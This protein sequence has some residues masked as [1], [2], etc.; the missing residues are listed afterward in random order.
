M[1]RT[2]SRRLLNAAGLL[3]AVLVFNFALIHMAPGDPVEVLAG[4]MGG[5]TPELLAE[6]RA[7]YGLDR[8]FHVQ[9]L[10]YLGRVAQGDLGHSFYYDQ[11][12]T[13]L[14]LDRIGATLLLVCAALTLALLLGCF[15]G[16][17]SA[18]NRNGWLS[19]LVT[20]LSLAGFSAPVFW[21][22]ILLILT[23]SVALPVLPISGMSSVDAGR[24]GPWGRAA[25]VAAHMVLPV[26][27]LASIY[28][29]FYSRLARASMLD[30]LGSDYVRT[31][32]AKGL[33]RFL[34]VYKH[35]LRNALLPV[36]TFAGLQFAQVVSGA[37]LVE[38]VFAWPGLGT[39][40]YESLLRRDSPTLLGIL[41]FSALMVVAV[42]IAV[43]L[44]YRLID[45]R[46]GAR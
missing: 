41:F 27:T 8:P 28:L 31:A 15:L 3:L 12:V 4:E 39:L 33:S 25:D 36:V 42:N 10:T 16:V 20:L 38:T 17:V 29:A 14:I 7:G 18:Q 35:A 2:L 9:L 24:M 5:A 37:V 32:R 26:L 6:I 21:V 13:G 30:V 45:P 19:H 23:F 40:A 44:L 43:D 11:P 46:I 34:V 1:I 22:G